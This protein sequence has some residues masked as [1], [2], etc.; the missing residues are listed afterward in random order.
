MN[1]EKYIL[2]LKISLVGKGNWEKIQLTREWTSKIPQEAGVYVLKENSKLVYV[3]ETG[4]LRGRMND[5]LDTR[6]HSVR[7]TIGK[8]YFNN[9]KGFIPATTKIKFPDHIERLVN[10]Y[11]TENLKIAYLRVPLGRKELEEFIEKDIYKEIKLNSRGKRK[12]N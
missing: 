2:D 11:I 12:T 4:N 1:V 7:R 8:K 6:H 3:G 5:L 9:V 10:K